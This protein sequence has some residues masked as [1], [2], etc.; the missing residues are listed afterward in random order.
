MPL[1]L[2]SDTPQAFDQF[3]AIWPNKKGKKDARKAWAQA[4]RAGHS[5]AEIIGG[6]E[7]YKRNKPD[8]QAWLHPATYIR[9]ER[10]EDEYENPN[11]EREAALQEVFG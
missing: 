2:V 3:W 11:A 8:W 9:G 1:R 5:P 7:P 6:V 10:W 4:M